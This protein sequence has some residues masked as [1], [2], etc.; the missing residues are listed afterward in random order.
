MPSSLKVSLPSSEKTFLPIRL[1]RFSAGLTGSRSVGSDGLWIVNFFII[2]F[3]LLRLAGATGL[4]R[5]NEI[6]LADY[7]SF[8]LAMRNPGQ[9]NPFQDWTAF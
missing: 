4:F 6:I 3:P 1:E 2:L 8:E 7:G 9:P 5:A